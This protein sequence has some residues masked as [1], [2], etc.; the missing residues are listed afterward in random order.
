LRCV[1]SRRV[2]PRRVAQNDS[3]CAICLVAFAL[4][5]A[6]GAVDASGAPFDLAYVPL[7]EAAE[8]IA[9]AR[10]AA[11]VARGEGADVYADAA[12]VDADA[13][14]AG[15][16]AAAASAANCLA[17]LRGAPLCVDSS[18]NV[19]CDGPCLQSFHTRCLRARGAAL[20]LVTAAAPA[21]S[22]AAE[23]WWLC[24][25]CA[26]GGE[27][28]CFACAA[29]LPCE[30]IVSAGGRNATGRAGRIAASMRCADR[31]CGKAFCRACLCADARVAWRSATSARCPLHTCAV[32]GLTPPDTACALCPTAYCLSCVPADALHLAD[33]LCL[34]AAHATAPN[35]LAHA[36]R[37]LPPSAAR[38]LA[39]LAAEAARADARAR[40]RDAARRHEDVDALTLAERAAWRRARLDARRADALADGLGS[41]GFCA[42]DG[43]VRFERG[44]TAAAGALLEFAPWPELERAS[45]EKLLRD[46]ASLAAS[47]ARAPAGSMARAL[48]LPSAAEYFAQFG[49]EMELPD[50][51]RLAVAGARRG[52]GGGARPP[53]PPPLPRY[54]KLRTNLYR[55]E[56]PR[57][58]EVGERC[59]CV[60]PPPT[61]A[62]ARPAVAEPL[63]VAALVC[64]PCAQADGAPQQPT[65]LLEP[66]APTP[67]TALASASAPPPPTRAPELSYGG[68]RNCRSAAAAAALALAASAD[69]VV[70]CGDGCLNRELFIECDPRSCPC[71]EAC[72]NQ[73]L[74][75]KLP[76]PTEPFVTVGKGWGLR[77]TARIAAGTFIIEYV[78]EVID[79]AECRRRLGRMRQG[80]SSDDDDDDDDESESESE[81]EKGGGAPKARDGKRAPARATRAS[82]RAESD[83]DAASDD[84]DSD[85]DDVD[86]SSSSSDS[87]E[88]ARARA[89]EGHFF[90]M[91]VG[92]NAVIDASRRGN[93]ARFL[94]HSCE[95]NSQAQ[96]W[97]VKVRAVLARARGCVVAR[98]SAAAVWSHARWWWVW[99]PTNVWRAATACHRPRPLAR[100]AARARSDVSIRRTRS[101]AHRRTASLSPCPACAPWRVR[102]PSPTRAAGARRARRGSACTRTS[103]SRRARRS[104]S[105]TTSSASASQSPAAAARPTAAASSATSSPSSRRR[106]AAAEPRRGRRPPRRAAPP[107]RAAASSRT[108]RCASSTPPKRLK[109]PSPPSARRQHQAAASSTATT[110]RVWRSPAGRR[111][112]CAAT[113]RA[114]S[115][116]AARR[117]GQTTRRRSRLECGRWLRPRLRMRTPRKQTRPR[118]CACRRRSPPS[119]RPPRTLARRS[120]A[121]PP[122]A[123]TAALL[124]L[125]ARAFPPSSAARRRACKRR[126]CE[127]RARRRRARR[128]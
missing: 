92:P 42:A 107:K 10:A 81:I 59:R 36:T 119:R 52:S 17:H 123:A 125:A 49:T 40:A 38:E 118:A 120:R 117:G 26:D 96:K 50:E 86:G 69:V 75:R 74:S 48:R 80:E 8:A 95:P 57:H 2:A 51:I 103:R 32:C 83:D 79:D 115:S 33:R 128:R 63:A 78:G 6:G 100:P 91:E 94:N 99:E 127:H 85:D 11:A 45:L 16:G 70:G 19:A 73:P 114:A 76:A 55:I 24:G 104:P 106:R 44:A 3:Y 7:A 72:S 110:T 20:G 64:S 39:L 21:G 47:L 23:G 14:A 124:G 28:A 27:S 29:P 84:S 90:I 111:S 60:P 30:G 43:A 105:I 102:A 22:E 25:H 89:S 67:A 4:D 54:G 9:A 35:A 46:R 116:R 65:A 31:L 113:A 82:A 88:E 121:P 122:T 12:D 68:E 13:D 98:C 5:D 97:T 34:C 41:L 56:R 112:C 1:A 15:G 61:P 18:P 108:P 71:G 101:R 87:D 77:A 37:V 109:R 53:R 62:Q 58:T 126:L 93:A 66:P